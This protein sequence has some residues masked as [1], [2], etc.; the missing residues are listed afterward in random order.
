M[1]YD[2]AGQPD[3]IGSAREL[4]NQEGRRLGGGMMPPPDRR[5]CQ[6][7]IV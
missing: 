7:S 5:A 3:E 4:R 1:S 2:V 6:A